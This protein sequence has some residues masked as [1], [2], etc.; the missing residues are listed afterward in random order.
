MILTHMPGCV[1]TFA[2][3]VVCRSLLLL[4]LPT[5]ELVVSTTALVLV[6]NS[7]QL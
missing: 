6:S 5:V 7:S 1:V 2:V 4:P 3:A